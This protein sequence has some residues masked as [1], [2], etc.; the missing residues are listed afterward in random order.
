MNIEDYTNPQ[1]S[2][3]KDL[4][5]EIHKLKQK[6]KS[7]EDENHSLHSQLSLIKIQER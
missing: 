6:I 7:L 5:K 1:F 4:E 2:K 3:I